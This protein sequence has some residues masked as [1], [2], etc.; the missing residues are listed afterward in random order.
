MHPGDKLPGD[1]FDLDKDMAYMPE[2]SSLLTQKNQPDGIFN[3]LLDKQGPEL[4]DAPFIN[5]FSST[6]LD[7]KNEIEPFNQK[8]VSEMD[9]NDILDI[10]QMNNFFHLKPTDAVEY[11]GMTDFMTTK[12]VSTCRS[13]GLLEDDDLDHSESGF[14]LE[15]FERPIV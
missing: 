7:I 6:F 3:D 1:P 2:A 9:K 15:R 11:G 13:E 5:N 8:A 12:K 10:E 14:N 4:D